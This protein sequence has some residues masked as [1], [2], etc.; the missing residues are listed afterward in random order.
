[1]SMNS[2]TRILGAVLA[3]ALGCWAQ[4]A[5]E[6]AS[7]SGTVK[8]QTGAV[9]TGAKVSLRNAQTGL[10]R[11]IKSSADGAYRFLQA[12]PGVYE[13]RAEK[14]GFQTKLI[15]ELRLSIGQAATLDLDLAVGTA[16][17]VVEVTGQAA[18]IESERTNQGNTLQQEFVRNLPIDRRDYLSFSLLAPGVVDSTA[19]ADNS[20]FRVTQTP[21]SG[22]SFYGSNG[23]GNSITVDGSEANEAAGGVRPTLSQEAVE[24]FQINRSNYTAEL[25]GASGGV[26]NIVSRGGGNRVRGTGFGFFRHQSLDAG[27]PFARVLEGAAVRRVKPDATRQ[28]VGGSIGGPIKKD[29]TFFFAAAEFLNRDESNVVSILTDRS[30]FGAT[31]EQEA[32]LSRLPEAAAAQLRGAL[33][34]SAATVRLFETNGGVTPFTGNDRKVSLRLDHNLNDNNQFNFRYSFA[35]AIETNASTRALVGSSRGSK[36]D[37]FDSNTAV[38]WT[39]I[40]NATIVND[41]RAQWNYYNSAV[42]SLDSIG[43]ELNINGF[44]LFGKDIFLPFDSISRRYEIKDT[45]AVAH[46]AHTIKAGGQVLIRSNHEDSK[47]FFGGRFNFGSLPAGLVNPALASTTITALQAFNLGLPQSYQQGFGDPIVTATYPFYSLFLQD[48]WKARPN[49]TLD[50]GLRYELDT[51]K[52]PMPT[53][54]NNV[55]PRFGF[56]WDP[57]GDGKTSVRGGYG[58]YYSPIYFQVDYVVNALGIIDG[59]RQIPQILTTIQTAGPAAANN[60]YSTLRRQG[61]IGIPSSTRRIEPADLAQFGIN[62]SQTGPLPPF[63]VV[64]ENSPNYVN[65][66]SQ[67]ATLS[68]ERQITRSMSIS[69]SGIWSRT[70]KV[71][72][73]RNKNLL[74]TA[75]VDP[76]LG[77]KVWRTQ[78]FANPLIFQYNVYESSANAYY[79]GLIFEMRRRLSKSLSLAGNYTFSRAEDEVTDFNSDFQANDQSNLRAERSLSAF[80]QRHKFVVYGVWQAPGKL[81]V[82]PIFRANSGRPF[83]LLV[84]ADI[85]ADRHSNTDRPPGAGRNTGIGPAFYTVDLRLSKRIRLGSS[86]HRSVELLAEGFNLSNR[87]NYSSVNNTVGLLRGPFNVTGRHDRS[88]SEAL[89]F[90]SAFDPR[91][92]QLGVRLSF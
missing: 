29:Q 1:M 9:V 19:M 84:G 41:L 30:I 81:Q 35:Q 86:E 46:G 5:S 60:I 32:I 52:A 82:A 36:T 10:E 65:P 13:L 39:R 58:I 63:S 45:V 8:D 2:T 38:G 25:G 49:L 79:R 76:T 34:S 26:I 3:A 20:D 24:E 90:T 50:I 47:T 7:L 69:V 91:R 16:T 40:L 66:Y 92:I 31:R 57:F 33:T 21:T 61:V 28:Q 71:T 54:K 53:D 22:L 70:L 62:I 80:H 12:P 67:Q 75:P 89:G 87:L 51:R 23:R 83:N 56:A 43:P 6:S 11:E 55:A 78:D 15:S 17:E 18:L 72:R 74:P 85:N 88:P 73:A 59:R 4:S 44:G 64:F 27:D 37:R 68:L 48:T 77:I 42:T 14:D